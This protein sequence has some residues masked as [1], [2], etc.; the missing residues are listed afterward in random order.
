MFSHFTLTVFSDLYIR[1]NTAMQDLVRSSHYVFSRYELSIKKIIEG[2]SK[3]INS[4]SVASANVKVNIV[5]TKQEQRKYTNSAKAILL[6]LT[7]GGGIIIL[8][9]KI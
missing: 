6:H 8:L 2:L 7:N 3:D 5:A 4:R 1:K 9:C